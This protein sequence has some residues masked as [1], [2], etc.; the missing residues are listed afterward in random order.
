MKINN[1]FLDKATLA[2]YES[3]AETEVIADASSVGLSAM[4]SQKKR[5][6]HIPVTY[7]SRSLSSA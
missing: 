2:Y 1:S 6:G 5:D 4:L 7:I 3:G